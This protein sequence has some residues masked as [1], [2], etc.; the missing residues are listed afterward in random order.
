MFTI[1]IYLRFAIM[2]LL[3]AIGVAL[4]IL[5]GFWYAFPLFLGFLILL[6]GYL[7]L[8]TVQ[9]A[10]LIMQGGDLVAA[11][12][13]LDLT[14]T[15][16]LLYV[17]NRAYYFL[18]KG[19]IAMAN[20]QTEAG[21]VWLRKA[22]TLKLPSDNE[23]AMI[24]LQFASIHLNKSRWKQAETHLRN[25]KQLKVT[26]PMLKE[27]VVQLEKA[28]QQQ[29]QVKAANRMGMTRGGQMPLK[30]GGKRRRPPIR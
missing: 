10:A 3:L 9:S 16:R 8:G 26:E 13:R 20:K 30:P 19:S 7:L 28:L 27:Q 1:N 24:E 11:A 12:K 4:A 18:L 2:G 15:P 14:L 29:G 22:Q 6:V 17:T 5:F 21:E 23:R 25:I